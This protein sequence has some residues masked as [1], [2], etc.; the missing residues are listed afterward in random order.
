M[1][2]KHIHKGSCHINVVIFVFVCCWASGKEGDLL[3]LCTHVKQWDFVGHFYLCLP[4]LGHRERC[5]AMSV[6]FLVPGTMHLTKATEGRGELTLVTEVF[7][8]MGVK[9][10]Q[11]R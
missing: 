9:A 8:F 2:R 7:F 1:K 4:A 10:A 3:S 6:T 5:R 11:S